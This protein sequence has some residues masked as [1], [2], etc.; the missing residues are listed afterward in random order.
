MLPGATF[1]FGKRL[2]ED[3]Q[4]RAMN[5]PDANTVSAALSVRAF[6]TNS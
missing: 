6:D 4:N 3:Q 5:Q 2:I 1:E